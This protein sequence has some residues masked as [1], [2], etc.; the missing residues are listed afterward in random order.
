MPRTSEHHIDA[1][2]GIPAEIAGTTTPRKVPALSKN[3]RK[4]HELLQT[5]FADFQR[6]LAEQQ[7]T[8]T[9]AQ[10]NNAA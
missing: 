1:P 6:E 10:E 2:A 9:S 5:L 7:D 3:Q 4:V 8:G